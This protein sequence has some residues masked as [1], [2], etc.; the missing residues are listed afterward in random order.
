MA[1]QTSSTQTAGGFVAH[2]CLYGTRYIGM[3]WLASPADAS[4]VLGD[5]EPVSTRGESEAIWE[6]VDAVRAAGVQAGRVL[7]CAAGGVAWTTVDLAVPVPNAGN[8]H[9]SRG[10]RCWRP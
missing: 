3:G 9:W 8:L 10:G 4:V 5:G 1:A 7:V 6:A 2:I